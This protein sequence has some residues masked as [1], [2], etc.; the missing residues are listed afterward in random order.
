LKSPRE[1]KIEKQLEFLGKR[2]TLIRPRSA[3]SSPA[4][5]ALAPARADKRPR[6]LA[7]DLAPAFPLPRSHRHVGPSCRRLAQLARWPS[8]SL[9]SGVTLSAPWPVV[10]SRV[11]VAVP[12]APLASPSPLLQPLACA[13][14]AYA[15]RDRCTH[16]TS[17]R[18]TGILTP[19]SS[20]R[21]P[22]PPLPYSFRPCTLTQAT[23]THSSSFPKLP[24]R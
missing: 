5:C 2:K 15:R 12:R 1:N 4:P 22:P 7:V 11:C 6:L 19:S 17:Q 21:T 20:P 10:R 16:A 23:R 9:P 14:R 24:R 18:Q 3:Q 8:P 13:D